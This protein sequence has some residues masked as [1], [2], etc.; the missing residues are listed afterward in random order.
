MFN[1]FKANLYQ[2][3]RYQWYLMILFII[4]F[5]NSFAQSDAKISKSTISTIVIDP[6]H[7]G[8]DPGAL[9]K[10]TQEKDIVLA[11]GLKLGELIAEDFPE[12]RLIYTRDTDIFIPLDERANIANKNHAD[13]FISIHANSI[14]TST[15]SGA[16]TYVLGLHRAEDNLEVAKR[17]NSVILLEEDYMTKYEGFDPNSPE[18]YIIFS[19]MQNVFFEQSINFGSYV[20]DELKS[21][22]ERKNRGVKQAG[23]LVLARTTM[24]GALIETGFVSNQDEEKYLASKEGQE[25]IAKSIFTAFVEYKKAIDNMSSFSIDQ[26]CLD[27]PP[28]VEENPK[29]PIPPDNN[30]IRFKVQINASK[31]EIPL[32]SEYF[33]GLKDI[34]VFF[35]GEIYKYAV[36]TAYSYAD[37]LEYSKQV[38][39]IFPDAFIIALKNNEIIPVHKA[40]KEL[41][42]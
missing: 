32:N 22:A 36:G 3:K 34:E 13:L 2:Q 11:I 8:K 28:V 38:K 27:K 37:I 16:E 42:N 41:Q 25:K 40:L 23:F 26:T 35:V 20:Q 12:I 6:G 1:C 14:S 5:I 30:G 19:L 17:E 7:G 33:K 24:P 9:G 10:T 21:T 39:T 18:S 15:S 31:S 29:D 4:F